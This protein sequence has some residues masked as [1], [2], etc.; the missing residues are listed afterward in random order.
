[1]GTTRGL[2]FGSVAERYE[3]YRT[4][5]P[6][7]L[8]D[9]VTAYAGRPIRTALEVGAGTG[10]ATRVFA[11]RGVTVT[12]IEPDADMRAMLSRTTA[13]LPVRSVAS[14]FEDF[15]ADERF[16]LV[17]AAASWHWTRPPQRWTQAVRLLEDGG[18]LA[19]VRGGLE[20]ADPEVL[21]TVEDLERRLFGED[22]HGGHGWTPEEM[23]AV[24]GLADVVERELPLRATGTADELVG[25]LGTV[26]AYLQLPPVEQA[27]ALQQVRDVL[28]DRLELRG[29]LTVSL[30]RRVSP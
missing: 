11:R 27:A 7:A 24:D 26:S 19:L 29:T 10:K 21:A 25:R 18:V 4:G 17:Y 1:M 2:L 23:G 13:D 12:A 9:V 16:D 3:R 30:A 28:P 6:D 20:P 5:Y 8:V 14:T 15:D 22:N